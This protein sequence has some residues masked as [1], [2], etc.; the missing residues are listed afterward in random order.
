MLDD[1]EGE[2]F[3]TVIIG[4]GMSGLAAGIRLALFQKKVL[5]LERHNAIGGL[6]S[7]YSIEGRKYD[8]GLHAITNYTAA[9]IKG[10]ALGKIFRQLRIPRESF[11]LSEQRSS[12][13]T[14]PGLNLQ[15][16]N[17]YTL[18]ESEIA[19]CFPQAI[20]GFKKLVV[21]IED[22]FKQIDQLASWGASARETLR[23]YLNTPLL[24]E[25]LLLP[26]MYYGNARENDMDWGQFCII[27]QSIFLE[28][29]ARPFEGIRLILRI[30]K[31]KYKAL[32]GIRKMKCGVKTIITQND[33]VQA[34]ELDDG[35][36]ITADTVLAS[37]GLPETL[38]I[39]NDQPSHSDQDNQGQLSFVETTRA[40]KVQPKAL[41]WEETIVFFNDSKHFSYKKPNDAI[42]PHSGVICMPNN[43][44][45]PDGLELP[46]GLVRT[47]ALANYEYWTTLPQ[48]QYEDKKAECFETLTKKTLEFLPATQYS[49]LEELTLAKDMFTPRTV[50]KYT[51]H[52]GGAIYGA[53]HK[54]RDGRTHLKNLYICGTDQGYLG[55]VGAMIS[56]IAMANQ[57]I[58]AP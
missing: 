51:G 10:S 46:E 40:L 28:G 58:L 29:F 39:C 7:F 19:R 49:T 56:G 53:P 34:L 12:R 1:L 52:L 5:I 32:G 38:R 36:R 54:Q 33:Q 20:D 9:G 22:S 2:H 8:V 15:F 27:F 21:Y 24:I 50:Q 37:I 26:V 47:T 3:D 30:L 25:A 13:I 17:D 14:F 55:I 6:N 35:R 57:H 48:A 23:H 18:F 11:Q 43:Y 16:N 41:G 31:D 4:A 44:Q 45:Y 42:D